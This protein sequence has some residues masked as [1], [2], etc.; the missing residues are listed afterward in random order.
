VATQITDEA[1]L[2]AAYIRSK[3]RISGKSDFICNQDITFIEKLFKEYPD[4]EHIRDLYRSAFYKVRDEELPDEKWLY[5]VSIFHGYFGIIVYPDLPDGTPVITPSKNG[6]DSLL[7]V[8]SRLPG[9]FL[10]REGNSSR[11]ATP[12]KG[13]ILSSSQESCEDHCKYHSDTLS[14]K[15]NT[16]TEEFKA[17]M[18]KSDTMNQ[19]AMD[20]EWNALSKLS[21]DGTSPVQVY[22]DRFN[23]HMRRIKR[24]DPDVEDDDLRMTMHGQLRNAKKPPTLGPDGER[25]MG[26]E[27]WLG[28]QPSVDINTYEKLSAALKE[29]YGGSKEKT[30]LEV[31]LEID[32]MYPNWKKTTLKEFFADVDELLGTTTIEDG[33]VIKALNEK[34]PIEVKEDLRRSRGAWKRMSLAKYREYCLGIYEDI[35][36]PEPTLLSRGLSADETA[37]RERKHVEEIA[38]LRR[39]LEESRLLDKH[40]IDAQKRFA[41]SDEAKRPMKGRNEA[42]CWNCWDRGHVATSCQPSRSWAER[43]KLREQKGIPAPFGWEKTLREGLEREATLRKKEVSFLQQHYP[44]YN[45]DEDKYLQTYNVSHQVAPAKRPGQRERVD[46]VF[47]EPHERNGRHQKEKWSVCPFLEST[48]VPVPITELAKVKPFSV[49]IKKVLFPEEDTSSEDSSGEEPEEDDPIMV[50]RTHKSGKQ[51]SKQIPISM[52]S[53]EEDEE[54]DESP[55][56]P[57]RHSTQK[58]SAFTDLLRI[59]QM[60]EEEFDRFNANQKKQISPA[61]KVGAYLGEYFFQEILVDIGADCNLIDLH[62]AK[63]IIGSTKDCALRTD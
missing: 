23:H 25:Y 52:E 22:L 32:Q 34:L 61:I 46:T 43:E 29:R 18:Q 15:S 45:E 13:D 6:E 30:S 14:D 11:E 41:N 40:H 58:T 12:E 55:R 2:A 3:F 60:S 33:F 51:Q 17:T 31:V 59:R 49:D 54:D 28:R 5:L 20:R 8:V 4:Q 57:G 9:A 10:P 16:K 63:K 39:Q 1:I 24:M 27:T 48:K 50:P 7:S 37:K 35:H 19:A 42:L 21:Y 53:D 36:H 26:P 38:S 56:P 62:T 47:P 44:Q